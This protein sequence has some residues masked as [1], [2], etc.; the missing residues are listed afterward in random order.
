[1]KQ[2]TESEQMLNNQK[3]ILNKINTEKK[4]LLL[5]SSEDSEKYASLKNKLGWVDTDKIIDDSIRKVLELEDVQS[6][7]VDANI[8]TMDSIMK[9]CINNN[10]VLCSITEYKGSLNTELLQAIDDYATSKGLSLTSGAELDCLFLLCP[11][12]DI[13]DNSEDIKKSKRYKKTNLSKILLLEKVTDKRTHS[14]DYYSLIFEIGNKKP[15]TNLIN[16]IFRTY[17]KSGNL[18]NNSIFYT[19]IFIVLA[20]I[21]VFIRHQD[22][23]WYLLPVCSLAVVLILLIKSYIDS[24][25]GPNRSSDDGGHLNVFADR[26]FYDMDCKDTIAQRYNFMWLYKKYNRDANYSIVNKYKNLVKKKFYISAFIL[27][28][29]SFC[30]MSIGIR[31]NKMLILN[32]ADVVF[33]HDKYFNDDTQDYE[34]VTERYY[35]TGM[36]TYDVDRQVIDLSTKAVE[37]RRV[38]AY[39]KAHPKK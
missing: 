12:K 34:A 35:K 39:D 31:I 37:K 15:I 30:I 23:A 20:I 22:C 9:Y 18:L 32:K 28:G 7:I 11:L 2:N 19:S 6:K 16:S 29:L 8:F 25:N 4:Q 1:M 3:V 33:N 24:F 36:L 14:E 27:I 13:Q 10:Y 17:T 38:E 5:S 26:D 21:G